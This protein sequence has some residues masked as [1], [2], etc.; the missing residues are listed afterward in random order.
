MPLN[1]QVS[2]QYQGVVEPAG[3]P[4][5]TT[6]NDLNENFASV[7]AIPSGFV[8]TAR[9]G[10]DLYVGDGLSLV[11]LVKT[12]NAND[13]GT[14]GQQGF[15]VGVLSSLPSGFSKMTGTE[16]ITSDNYGNYQYSDGSI[17]VWIPAFYYKYGTG[18]NGL[19]I[20]AV[21]IRAYSSF[22]DVTAANAA[23]YALHRAF[24]NAGVIQTGVFVDKYLC[25]NNSGTASS[26]KNGLP[27]SSALLHNPFSGLTGTPTNAYYGAIVAAKTRGAN[28]FCN[29]RFIFSALALL[30]L[31][32]GQ[33]ATSTTAC[34]WYDATGV[35]NFPKG[36][37]NTAFGDAN[38]GALTFV[39]D[40]YVAN[41]SNKTGSA[42]VPAKVAHNGQNSGVMDLNGTLWEINLGLVTDATNYYLLKT[43][44]DI[45]TITS[46]NTLAT[47]A[48]GATG[49]A[50]MYDSLGPT[51]GAALASGT[52]KTIGSATQVLDASLT[53]LPWAATGAG[54][55]LVG[56]VGGT[57]QFGNDQFYDA[58]PT[59]LCPLGGGYWSTSSPAGIWSL[60][61]YILN[62][63]DTTDS[64]VGFRSALYL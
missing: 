7:S 50:A 46:G 37:N 3:S 48:W 44:T 24:Y 9:V 62:V 5:H 23:G 4:Q 22:T 12:L 21:S 60:S 58:R 28:F 8:G 33:A 27:L 20:N 18:A 25:S 10:T 34:A 45:K 11:K 57:N 42:N 14:A 55:P 49:I 17:M 59:N 51:Y 56:G 61:F 35:N 39:W 15:G 26:I 36:C 54:I 2:P 43:A 64:S 32:H 13:I 1:V 38:D 41:N 30:S 47:D 63:R 6:V 31:A 53:G 19:A 52:S 29:S 16:D 40:G